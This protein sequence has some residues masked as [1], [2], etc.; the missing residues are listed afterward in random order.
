MYHVLFSPTSARI[1]FDSCHF[2]QRNASTS[3]S[4]RYMRNFR[5]RIARSHLLL[6][7]C[8]SHKLL[9]RLSLSM[10]QIQRREELFATEV[11][12]QLVNRYMSFRWSSPANNQE[13]VEIDSTSGHDV[14]RQQCKWSYSRR[15]MAYAV[16]PGRGGSVGRDYRNLNGSITTII[17]VIWLLFFDFRQHVLHPEAAFSE[18]N[19]TLF[20]KEFRMR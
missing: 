6:F 3:T 14:W 10:L 17:I 18:K 7:Y 4:K 8:Q 12:L 19:I 20:E 15:E 2:V 13:L 1:M 11:A 9:Y 5:I 16:F